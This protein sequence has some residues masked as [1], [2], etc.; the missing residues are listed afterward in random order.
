MSSE[1]TSAGRSLSFA[2]VL[3]AQLQLN[4]AQALHLLYLNLNQLGELMK[5]VLSLCIL[6]LGHSAFAGSSGGFDDPPAPAAK[7]AP[8]PSPTP[9]PAAPAAPAKVTPSAKHNYVAC[10]ASNT[11]WEDK[12]EIAQDAF[13]DILNIDEDFPITILEQKQVLSKGEAPTCT[14][15]GNCSTIQLS[16]DRA[17]ILVLKFDGS[18]SPSKFC[19]ASDSRLRMTVD[20]SFGTYILTVDRRGNSAVYIQVGGQPKYNAPYAVQ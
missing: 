11:A 12:A 14:G 17:G 13:K 6:I 8:K 20:T 19:K 2:D 9:S 10:N 7:P 1:L 18:S 16:K 5:L 4:Q 15:S 3:K